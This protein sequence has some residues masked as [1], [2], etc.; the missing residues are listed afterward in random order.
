[1][2]IATPRWTHHGLRFHLSISNEASLPY[3]SVGATFSGEDGPHDPF[4]L[5]NVRLFLDVESLTIEPSL[6]GNDLQTTATIPNIPYL[7]RDFIPHDLTCQQLFSRNQDFHE[8]AASRYTVALSR[9]DRQIS[10][11]PFPL[12]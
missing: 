2:E 11:S 8:I 12:S 5:D 1:V 10:G 7:P 3:G 4:S 9:T 6:P